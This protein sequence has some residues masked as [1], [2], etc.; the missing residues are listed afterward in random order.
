MSTFSRRDSSRGWHLGRYRK[1]FNRP[2]REQNKRLA[3]PLV[4]PRSTILLLWASLGYKQ[5]AVQ[6]EVQTPLSEAS[7]R[8]TAHYTLEWRVVDFSACRV[9]D[10]ELS[11]RSSTSPHDDCVL[12]CEVRSLFSPFSNGCAELMVERGRWLS[13]SGS[14]VVSLTNREIGEL[15]RLCGRAR[16]EGATDPTD[17]QQHKSQQSIHSHHFTRHGNI[18]SR[19]VVAIKPYHKLPQVPAAQN[20]KT[21]SAASASISVPSP[22]PSSQ[23]TSGSRRNQV[24]CR[25]A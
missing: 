23:C 20:W 3:I 15:W 22:N 25:L 5:R 17:Q 19:V 11:T 7:F 10:D 14:F 18:D 9:N 12:S 4:I 2:S 16:T 13:G 24:I 1:S 8:V 6:L 21:I